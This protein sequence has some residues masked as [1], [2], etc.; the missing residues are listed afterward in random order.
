[1]ETD[2]KVIV[3]IDLPMVKKENINIKL[4][5]EGLEVEAYLK[6]GVVFRGWGVVQGTREFKYLYKLIPL[7]VPIVS[8][9]CHAEFKRGILRVELKKRKDKGY[10]I[11]IK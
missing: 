4:L 3:T 5:D 9:G 7:P 6:R 2:D 11:Q 8:E 10:K 1:M